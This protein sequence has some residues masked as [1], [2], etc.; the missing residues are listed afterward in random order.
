MTKTIHAA[1]LFCGAGGTSQGYLN[2]CQALSARPQLL[3]VNHWPTAIATH[4]LNHPGVSHLC[5]SLENIDP[6]QSVPEGFLHL[7]C[8]SPECTHHSRAAGGRPKNEQSRA[9]AWRI[10]EWARRLNIQNILIENVPEFVDWGPLNKTGKPNKRKKGDIFVAF[11]TELKLLGY[12]V[13]WRLL[14]AADYG[15]PTTR[16]RLF[17]IAS[18]GP[19]TWPVPSYGRAVLRGSMN[20]ALAESHRAKPWRAAREIID[21]QLK[22]QSIF[23]RKKPLCQNT[24]RRI[25][26]GLR[27]FGGPAAKPFLIILQGTADGQLPST[28]RSVEDPA[29]TCTGSGHLGICEPFV[30]HTTHSTGD[31]G[32][33]ITDPIPTITTSHRGEMALIEPFLSSFHGGHNGERNI[34]SDAPL[35]TQDTQNR[36]A[37]VEPMLIG[38]QSCAAARPVNDPCPTI[39]TG[40]HIALVEPF[41]VKYYGSGGAKDL[42]GPLDTIT[43]RDRFM[44]VNPQSGAEIAEIDIL[45]RMLQPHELA[46]AQGFPP[47]YQFTGTRAE[48]VKQIGNAV[49]V[50]L[51]TALCTALLRPLF[52]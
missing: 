47:G 44:L 12:N 35:P 5:D 17:I 40:G 25:A 3:A 42:G 16:R 9:T 23:R 34:P 19:I 27:K 28:A 45:F 50:N 51:A 2:A 36:F 48:Q 29:P 21:W 37:L 8:A 49:P 1:D 6:R 24:L 46:G 26:A 11:I 31:R 10:L 18:R 14:I 32:T 30:M 43:S 13:E 39:A 38:Q 15:D 22:G 4:N 7:L 33:S 20:Q 41:I 52:S